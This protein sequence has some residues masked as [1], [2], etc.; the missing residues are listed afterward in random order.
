MNGNQHTF[1]TGGDDGVIK[2]WNAEINPIKTLDLT[3]QIQYGP[4]VR[5]MDVKTDGKLLIGTYGA[6]VLEISNDD[7]RIIN[8]ITEGHFRDRTAHPAEV[9]GCCVHPTKQLFATSGGDKTIRIWS[10]NKMVKCSTQF[11][12][13]ITAMDWSPGEAKY[14]IAGDRK[15]TAFLLN[16]ETLEILG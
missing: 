12:E 14:L 2:L 7:G 15:G 13:D 10:Q 11:A 4:G 9:W 1:W 8:R 3:S 5:S 6:S 16:A